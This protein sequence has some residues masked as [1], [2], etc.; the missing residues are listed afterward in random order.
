VPSRI[1]LTG[2][3]RRERPHEGCHG[4]QRGAR[5]LFASTAHAS[6]VDI[7]WPLRGWFFGVILLAALVP[8]LPM[9]PVAAVASLYALFG[10]RRHALGLGT[11]LLTAMSLAGIAMLFAGVRSHES[12]NNP[13]AI[14][15][16][17]IPGR[18]T[19]RPRAASSLL[20]SAARFSSSS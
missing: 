20:P 19:K 14:A 18:R 2:P 7:L 12:L 11:L 1:D 16:I 17:V 5:G 4:D 15:A 10:E 9:A 6:D 8:T 3:S 13:G